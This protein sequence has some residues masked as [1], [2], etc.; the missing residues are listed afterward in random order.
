MIPQAGA[1]RDAD[2]EQGVD[3]RGRDSGGRTSFGWGA[4]LLL[5]A[6]GFLLNLLP[7]RLSPGIDLVFGGL[8]AILA[9]V[10]LGP[11]WGLLAGGLAAA[12]TILLWG[13]P[14]GWLVL[15]LEAGVVG[16]V[17]RRRGSRPMVAD[18]LYWF[19]LGV[20]LV[21]LT[22][23]LILEVN[24]LTFGVLALKQT[25]NGV[26]NAVLVEMLLLV[27]RLR[28]LVRVPGAPRLQSAIAVMVTT[29]AIV[30][31]LAFGIWE[32]R[33]EWVRNL[34]RAEERAVAVSQAYASKLQQFV[35]LH[36]S[37]VRSAAVN[38]QRWE[39]YDAAR[40]QRLVTVVQ[41][42]F[43]ALVE[44]RAIDAAGGLVAS[45]SGA[46]IGSPNPVQLVSEAAQAELR[47][48]R[49][50]ISTGRLRDG[51][52]DEVPVL[53]SAFPIA[54]ADTFAG[55]AVGVI[56]LR[57]LP[58]PSPLP[59]RHERLLVSDGFVALAFSGTTEDSELRWRATDADPETFV[60]IRSGDAA[61]PVDTRLV[62]PGQRDA[63]NVAS[64]V[65]AVTRLGL[66]VWME[67]PNAWIQ[68]FVAESY[69]R[70]LALLTLMVLLGLMASTAVARYLAGPLLRIRGAAGALAA[71]DLDARV[72]ELP[73]AM[74]TE[75]RELGGEFDEM[76]VALELRGELVGERA[77]A[78]D[79]GHGVQRQEHCHDAGR[80]DG[81]ARGRPRPR[82]GQSR[83]ARARLARRQRAGSL[84]ARA[85]ELPARDDRLARC[86]GRSRVEP[87]GGPPRSL[88][89]PRRVSRC[90]ASGVARR[91]HRPSLHVPQCGRT[92]RPDRRRRPAPGAPHLVPSRSRPEGG[93]G[94]SRRPRPRAS[95]A[96]HIADASRKSAKVANRQPISKAL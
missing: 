70:L 3:S 2:P 59:E 75:I 48:L 17:V 49:G 54:H 16:Y 52:E 39:S 55:Y 88:C 41:E 96:G 40:L 22:T 12:P 19:I 82:R 87:V 47:E 58:G 78:G 92:H 34:D 43:P 93:P 71:G 42:Q 26:F 10:A 30:P 6:A 89:G 31:A 81:R 74:P 4:A 64:G 35:Q 63:P 13:H 45:S 8:P 85:F 91:R 57:A 50:A 67:A 83:Y 15:T 21:Y 20:P 23:V 69:L 73:L 61:D 29:A 38:A 24:L 51:P 95:M 9:G 37:A 28:A 72:G 27:P 36:E 77:C 79:R 46:R 44:L 68:A 66:W 84:R 56:D 62:I 18:L 60:R 32:G 86:G 80:P 76:A 5:G 11:A 90:E 33:R 94:S 53:I 65:S 14:W 7:L 1:A 25:L